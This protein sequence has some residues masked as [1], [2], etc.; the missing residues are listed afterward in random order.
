M[1][2]EDDLYDQRIQR[3]SEIEALGFQPY[4]QRFDFTQAIPQ[5]LVEYSDSLRSS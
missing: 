3:I 4:G 5:I 1:S 2:L